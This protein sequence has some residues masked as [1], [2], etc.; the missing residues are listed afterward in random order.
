M[1]D[2]ESP[3]AAARS[4]YPETHSGKLWLRSLA[5]LQILLT[6]VLLVPAALWYGLHEMPGFVRES[7]RPAVKTLRFGRIGPSKHTG[8]VW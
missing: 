4:G 5:V 3:R 7:I 2:R 1:S 6:V 8:V